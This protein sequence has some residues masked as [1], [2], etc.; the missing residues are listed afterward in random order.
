MAPEMHG[1]EEYTG[2]LSDI[3]SLGVVLFTM[4]FCDEPWKSTKTQDK[5]FQKYKEKRINL[6]LNKKGSRKL[7]RNRKVPK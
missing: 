5:N 4:Y 3:F 2:E 6:F 7:Y 1:T